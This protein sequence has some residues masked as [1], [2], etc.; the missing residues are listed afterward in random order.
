M[1]AKRMPVWTRMQPTSRT[2][3]RRQN[4]RF[5][6]CTTR[7][8]LFHRDADCKLE[9]TNPDSMRRCEGDLLPT[10]VAATRAGHRVRLLMRKTFR[11]HVALEPR[12]CTMVPVLGSLR[13]L[14]KGYVTHVG[15][16][17]L[18][19]I[20][21]CQAR[22]ALRGL[23]AAGIFGAESCK[24]ATSKATKLALSAQMVEQTFIHQEMHDMTWLSSTWNAHF[25]R[26]S[27]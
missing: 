11:T 5:Q 25:Q 6:E 22:V 17:S 21:Y 15:D 4:S 23:R 16:C 14:W 18:D 9:H 2:A 7:K 13:Q 26:R 1:N 8:R 27:I 10:S 19:P 3:N 12:G 24:R 20:P